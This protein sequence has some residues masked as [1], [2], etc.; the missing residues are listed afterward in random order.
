MGFLIA[1]AILSFAG[2]LLHGLVGQ[3]ILIGNVYKSDMQSL[4]KSPILVSLLGKSHK[5]LLTM[6]GCLFDG[7]NSI[8]GLDGDMTGISA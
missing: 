1:G 6:P 8:A 5:V 4:T 7:R 3:K 2:M